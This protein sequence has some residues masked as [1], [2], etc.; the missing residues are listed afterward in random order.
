MV[1]SSRVEVMK[2]NVIGKLKRNTE[3]KKK[4][5]FEFIIKSL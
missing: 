4:I 2:E 1:K 5:K 3:W